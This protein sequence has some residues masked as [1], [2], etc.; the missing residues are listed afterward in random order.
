[1]AEVI[2]I[3]HGFKINIPEN[4]YYYKIKAW[5]RMTEDFE[6]YE[7]TQEEIN[8]FEL[9]AKYRGYDR[10]EDQ[11]E[12]TSKEDF[13]WW[14]REK[15]D[16]G[17]E[18]NFG[19]LGE[20]I[21]KHCSKKKLGENASS[22]KLMRCIG[23][24]VKIRNNATVTFSVVLG[25]LESPKLKRLN[26]LSD[27]E[28]SALG[29]KE[30]K[31]IKKEHASKIKFKS[32]SKRLKEKG[33]RH[34][35][36]TSD[37]QFYILNRSVVTGPSGLK[38]IH[39]SMNIPYGNRHFSIQAYCFKKYCKGVEEKMA[40]IIEP[41][42]SINTENAKAYNYYKVDQMIKLVKTVRKGYRIYKLAKLL[43]FLI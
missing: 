37:A 29:K 33:V 30:I 15:D 21:D 6:F 7:L 20:I 18:E 24:Q 27:S 34:I 36:I 9:L 1:M 40:K 11:I 4:M 32:E 8:D 42:I 10:N 25:N 22:G 2:D 14:E 17:R 12:I 41:T 38:T 16:F 39:T 19:Y 3:G 26:S 31:N 5:D 28:L 35:K 23:E 43:I 13:D